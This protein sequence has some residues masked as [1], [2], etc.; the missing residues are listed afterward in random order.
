MQRKHPDRRQ[1]RAPILTVSADF[2]A[3]T[4]PAHRSHHPI[5]LL[6]SARRLARL[7]SEWSRWSVAVIGVLVGFALFSQVHQIP[8][9]HL[10]WLLLGAL[11][12]TP[13]VGK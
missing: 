6:R 7:R 11:H 8:Y 12:A 3:Y 1:T 5:A 9:Q 2:D 13:T 4:A 10:P